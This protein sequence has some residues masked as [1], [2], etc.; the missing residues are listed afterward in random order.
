MSSFLALAVIHLLAVASPGPDFAFITKQSLAHDRRTAVL[1]AAGLGCAVLLHCTYSILGVGAVI[2][3]SIL[4][5][6]VIKYIGAL[7]LIFIGIKALFH[8]KNVVEEQGDAGAKD[9]NLRPAKAFMTG[10]LCNALN[11]KATVFFLAVFVQVIDPSTTVVVR[12]AYALYMGLATFLWFSF[13]A[14]IF[15]LAAVRKCIARWQSRIERFMGALLIAMGLKV[16]FS[17]RE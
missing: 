9:E 10:F 13:L 5:F 4:L 3:N 2:A 6:N 14:S 1:G 17:G 12:F 8:R 11:P 15:T 7:Y 16:A